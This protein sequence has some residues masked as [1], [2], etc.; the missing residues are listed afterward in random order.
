MGNATACLAACGRAADAADA[1]DA[2]AQPP[3]HG[4]QRRRRAPKH[5][6]RLP[7]VRVR[8]ARRNRRRRRRRLRRP[9]SP[10]SAPW[11]A[12]AA[13]ESFAV[14]GEDFLRSRAKVPSAAA[15]AKLVLV[16]LQ[17]RDVAA[18][19]FRPHALRDRRVRDAAGARARSV[20]S[21]APDA[22]LVALC[23]A[24][25]KVVAGQYHRLVVAWALPS[26]A[27]LRAESPGAANALRALLE[28]AETDPGKAAARLK[29]VPR[30]DALA[31]RADL[32][33][34]LLAARA[35]PCLLSTAASETHFFTGTA[36]RRRRWKVPYVEVDADVSGSSLAKFFCS[37]APRACATLALVVQG[38]ADDELPERVLGT[39]QVRYPD[40][41]AVAVRAAKPSALRR[42]ITRTV[43]RLPLPAP[44]SRLL[45]RRRPVLAVLAV[46]AVGLLLARSLTRGKHERRRCY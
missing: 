38:N 28:D 41:A 2:P 23:F 6:V 10:R 33:A 20:A 35:R 8:G 16:E 30:L 17:A 40:V 9:P 31:S 42:L 11:W 18:G 37:R 14:R 5:A 3:Q 29:L 4:H 1:D 44:E 34:R 39:V 36:R 43:R 32:K 24:L 13:A 7:V 45:P 15:A 27:S 22:L 21:A 25:P 12:D 19:P 46:A 26:R